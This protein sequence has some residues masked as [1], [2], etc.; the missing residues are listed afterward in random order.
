MQLIH[1]QTFRMISLG[2]DARR[3]AENIYMPSHL[4]DGFEIY[5]QVE[6]HAKQVYNGRLGW[7]GNDVYDINPLSVN[8]ET[9]RMV[10][11]MGGVD[12]VRSAARDAVNEGGFPNWSWALKLTSLLLEIDENDEEARTVPR[13]RGTGSRTTNNL[14][15]RKGVVHHRSF[16]DGKKA[17][18]RRPTPYLG[19][20]AGCP[21]NPEC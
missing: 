9:R 6:S 17:E 18:D 3:A 4:R 5:G 12:K 19:D 11:M 2:M 13:G 1:D 15:Q 21:G 20:D 7:M 14:C 10:E 8:E 16:G